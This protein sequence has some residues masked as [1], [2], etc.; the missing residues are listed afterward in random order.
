MATPKWIPSPNRT[1]GRDGFRPEAIVVHVMEGT[2]PG[3]DAWFQNAASQVSAHYGIGKN[4]DVHQYVGETDQAWHAGR[5]FKAT[6]RGWRA[7]IKPNKYTIGIEHEGTETSDWPDAMYEASADLIREIAQRW[8]IPIDR[9]HVI[10]HREIYS[11][12]TCPGAKADLDRLVR[13]ARRE[14]I[15]AS[16]I[17]NFVDDPGSARARANLNIR[18]GAPTTE[19]GVARTASSGERL[20]FSGWTSNGEAVN[21][22]AHWYRTADGDY[23]WAG[24]TDRPIPGL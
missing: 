15:S 1:K 18:R 21:A 12:K 6:W 9:D 20:S 2:L 22:N 5:V 7:G 17:Y 3:T 4:G 14:A 13:L 11:H 24:A 19:A 8:S 23:F 16:G 10:G